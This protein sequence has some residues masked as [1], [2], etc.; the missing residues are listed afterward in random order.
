M[1]A[2]CSTLYRLLPY[3]IYGRSLIRDPYGLGDIFQKTRVA[4]GIRQNEKLLKKK[5]DAAQDSSKIKVRATFVITEAH[6]QALKNTVLSEPPTLTSM[7]CSHV[8]RKLSGSCV[9]DLK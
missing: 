9:A 7:N 6:I 1:E 8:N 4:R 2:L 3:P 5:E